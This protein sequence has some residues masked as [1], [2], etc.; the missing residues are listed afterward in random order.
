ML[1]IQRLWRLSFIF[2]EELK[3]MMDFMIVYY[4]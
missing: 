3:Y 1:Y 2:F 4:V